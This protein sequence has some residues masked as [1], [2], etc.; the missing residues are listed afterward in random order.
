MQLEWPR[1]TYATPRVS[2]SSSSSDA[3]SSSSAAS[4][5]AS[6]AAVTACPEPPSATRSCASTAATAAARRARRADAAT[7]RGERT[8]AGAATGVAKKP[9][10]G[11][12][13]ERSWTEASDAHVAVSPSTF[14][15]KGAWGTGRTQ[16]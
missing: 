10:L 6:P 12:K 3:S 1:K 5:S 2:T 14:K 13:G 15:E 9:A 4:A 7:V 16:R 11:K 8:A